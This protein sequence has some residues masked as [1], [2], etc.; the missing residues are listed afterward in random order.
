MAIAYSIIRK[1]VAG[2]M[3]IN[4]VDVTLDGS[5]AAGGYALTAASMGVGTVYNLSPQVITNEGVEAQWDQAGAK[6][7][8]V[9][10]ANT[11]TVTS[12]NGAYSELATNDTLISA[13]TKVRCVV[14]GD[15]ATG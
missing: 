9:K 10:G 3:R 15:M 1:G 13:N 2:N 4:I 14:I 11:V 5:Y 8:V 12:G 6:L 7:R